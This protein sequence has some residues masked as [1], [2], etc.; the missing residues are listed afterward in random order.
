[1][2][3]IEIL[4]TQKN[5][6]AWKN[7]LKKFPQNSYDVYFYS[8]Y[9]NLYYDMEKGSSPLLFTYQQDND[10]WIYPFVLRP[11]PLE[12]Q[13]TDQRYFDLES[14]YGYGGPLSTTNNLSFLV[15]AHASFTEWCFSK[16]VVAEFVRLHP[17]LE[18]EQWL[19]PKVKVIEERKTVSLDLRSLDEGMMSFSRSA[20]YML[21]RAEKFG[22]HV[23]ELPLQEN[24]EQF[25]RIYNLTMHR[26]NADE[27]Y[28]FDSKYF[29]NLQQLV[30]NHGWM[31]VVKHGPNW[32]AVSIFL[33]GVT[34]LHYFLSGSDPDKMGPGTINLLLFSAAQRGKQEGLE[35]LHFGGGQTN[36]A[37]DSLL[38]F[39]QSMSS[40][41]H[42]FKI[43][44]RIHNIELYKTIKSTW[45]KQ[46]PE[47]ASKY[48]Q[49]LLC[50]HYIN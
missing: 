7:I 2:I 26:L 14:A 50:Y 16:K 10:Y 42:I 34:Q 30:S 40:D 33:K 9:L 31:F 48:S 11:I 24:I 36:S 21:R 29:Q 38:K 23:E 3:K 17:I 49:Q 35:R 44:K 41:S 13:K 22:F 39:K 28:Y 15:N 5:K 4:E 32:V 1:M 27:F 12:L 18:N 37:D 6:E 8:E 47:L 45:E 20:R 19:D 46:Y 25:L 43:G